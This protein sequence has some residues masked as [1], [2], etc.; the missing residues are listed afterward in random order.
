MDNYLS[1]LRNIPYYTV[2]MIYGKGKNAANIPW[3]G[4]SGIVI[5]IIDD[6]SLEWGFSTSFTNKGGITGEGPATV[7]LLKKGL[8]FI[9]GEG[10]KDGVMNTVENLTGQSLED[11]QLSTTICK[12]NGYAGIDL[13]FSCTFF[14][15]MK[16]KGTTDKP[17][18][19]TVP[20]YSEFIKMLAGFSLPYVSGG[21][22]GI[23]DAMISGAAILLNPQ[24]SEETF[25]LIG[26]AKSLGGQDSNSDWIKKIQDEL[27]TIQIGK[28]FVGK[29]YWLESARVSQVHK[30]DNT[31]QPLIWTVSF[32]FKRF[33]QPLVSDIDKMF[34]PRDAKKHRTSQ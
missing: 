3:G 5:G 11:M 17:N 20:T 1:I 12:P 13:S 16:I 22:N 31:G 26:M 28:V 34:I 27:F 9:G 4:E 29:G 19:Y 15:N 10:F 7:G 32:S 14:H 30:Y 25:K 6:Q 18:P 24:V 21:E 8:S 2:T 23:I 33:A